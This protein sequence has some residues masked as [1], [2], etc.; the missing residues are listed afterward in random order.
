VIFA[1]LGKNLTGGRFIAARYTLN[2]LGSAGPRPVA[3]PIFY[4][5]RLRQSVNVYV[6]FCSLSLPAR[7]RDSDQRPEDVSVL[8]YRVFAGLKRNV[9]VEPEAQS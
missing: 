9:N 7:G 1:D 8:G 2:E 3:Q 5:G 6:F 4:L